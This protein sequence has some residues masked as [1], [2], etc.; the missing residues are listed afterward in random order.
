M[1]GYESESPL[2]GDLP[3]PDFGRRLQGTLISS[4]SRASG[5]GEQSL[6][7][8]ALQSE[9][10]RSALLEIKNL[11]KILGSEVIHGQEIDQRIG[12]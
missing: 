2:P 11:D 6:G 9:D 8:S 5:L 1:Q 10:V 12:Q 4:S 3:Q 7:S